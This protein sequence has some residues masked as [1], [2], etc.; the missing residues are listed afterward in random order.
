VPLRAFGD[1]PRL[2]ISGIAICLASILE[3]AQNKEGAYRV[4][5][6]AFLQLI[7]APSKRPSLSLTMESLEVLTVAEGIRAVSIACKLGELAHELKKPVADEEK[8]LVWSVD[9]LLKIIIKEG[10]RTDSNNKNGTRDVTKSVQSTLDE[11]S[12]PSWAMLHNFA[13]PFE[14]L[15]SFYARQGKIE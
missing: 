13:A 2:K 11:L 4:Y 8:W 12:L 14:A 3:A 5:E 9:A 1:E 10:L 15:G 7:N 6:D